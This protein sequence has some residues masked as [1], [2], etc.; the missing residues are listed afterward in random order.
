M[1][2][3][4]FKQKWKSILLIFLTLLYLGYFSSNLYGIRAENQFNTDIWDNVFLLALI[5]FIFH[6]LISIVMNTLESID[7]KSLIA[8]ETS[9]R[10]RLRFKAL[11]YRR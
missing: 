1:A 7:F 8:K 11:S 6:T 4:N 5:G 9:G 3:L 2:Y 10:M